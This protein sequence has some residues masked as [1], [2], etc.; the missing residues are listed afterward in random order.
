MGRG[1]G[2][3]GRK[4]KCASSSATHVSCKPG[5]YLTAHDSAFTIRAIRCLFTLLRPAY[6]LPLVARTKQPCK[7]DRLPAVQTLMHS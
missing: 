3:E 6:P 7:R 1:G 2:G 4:G 5:D